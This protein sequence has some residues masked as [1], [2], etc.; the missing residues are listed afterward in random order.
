VAK[1]HDIRHSSQTASLPNANTT[2]LSNR[3][4]PSEILTKILYDS[5]SSDAWHVLLPTHLTLVDSYLVI[6]TNDRTPYYAIF[7][8]L[9]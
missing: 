1:I 7:F 6:L 4:L 3:L 2:M 8:S 9:T 5:A